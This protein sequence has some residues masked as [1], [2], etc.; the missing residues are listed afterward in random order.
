MKTL[1]MAKSH[2]HPAIGAGPLQ[3]SARM[4]D[5]PR[6]FAKLRERPQARKCGC[7]IRRVP[8]Q[9]AGIPDEGLREAVFMLM[10]IASRG[11]A[12]YRDMQGFPTLILFGL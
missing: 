10:R 1:A 7:C 5:S 2:G 12:G 9:S 3:T 6:L 11:Y 8:R 4:R